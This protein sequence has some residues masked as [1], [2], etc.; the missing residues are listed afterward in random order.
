ME[1]QNLSPNIIAQGQ[2][3]IQLSVNNIIFRD[4]YLFMGVKLSKLP[5]TMGLQDTLKK[6]DFP[7][8]FNTVK[9]QNYIGPWPEIDYFDIDSKSEEERDALLAWHEECISQKLTFDFQKEILEYCKNDVLIL[10]EALIR[11]SNLIEEQTGG[12]QCFLQ[13]STIA[14]CAMECFRSR[15]LKENTIPII[16]PLGFQHRDQQ[17]KTA[18]QW[19]KYMEYKNNVK[20]QTAEN[21]GEVQFKRFKLDGYDKDSRTAYEFYGCYWHGHTCITQ[22][23]HYPVDDEGH[24]LQDRYKATLARQEFLESSCRVKVVY[25]W[26]CEWN[27]AVQTSPEIQSFI[28]NECSD[29]EDPLRPKDAFKGGVPNAFGRYINAMRTNIYN[30]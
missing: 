23:R 21:G 29:T 19:L 11:F 28:R 4:T 17:S 22:L 13:T 6:G 10:T 2:K 7:F 16:P 8:L 26:E 9:N 18:K 24:T 14:S 1:K 15:Y 20:L 12:I 30:T 27:K 5:S 3:I 25:T